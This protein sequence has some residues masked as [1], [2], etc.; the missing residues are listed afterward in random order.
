MWRWLV[1]VVVVGCSNS[2]TDGS[3]GPGPTASLEASTVAVLPPDPVVSITPLDDTHVAI[4]RGIVSGDAFCPDCVGLDPAQ[5]PLACTRTSI[6]LAILDTTTGTLG[7]EVPIQ[8]VFPKSFDHDV[9]ELQTVALGGNRVGLAWLDCD[10]S[11]CGA[12]AGKQSCSAR[13]S[14]IDLAAGTVGPI[15]TLYED[16]FGRLQLVASADH[17]LAVTGMSFGSYGAGVR[18][19]IFQHDGDP[20]FPWLALGGKD[21]LV[22][23]AAATA[24]GFAVVIEDR[25]P[26]DTPPAA[27]CP[28]SC[29][30]SG[31]I[32]IDPAGGGVYAYEL[33][34]TGI[35]RVD[36]VALGL[37]DDGHLAGGHY[38]DREVLALMRRGDDLVIAAGQAIDGAAELFVGRNDSWTTHQDFD[39]P[40]PLWI[41]VLGLGDTV[42]WIGS[43]PEPGAGSATIN[44]IVA[45]AADGTETDQRALTDPTDSYVFDAAPLVTPDGIE[46]TF[47]LRGVFDRSGA[48]LSWKWYEVV[49]VA[50]E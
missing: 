3:G 31:S 7:S 9:N 21:A 15:K 4:V 30:C 29:S 20:V 5:C 46:R 2:P 35:V 19:A 28:A 36:R 6:S 12:F 39:S 37:T 50:L 33:A 42:A 44:R 32:S 38:H 48:M 47:L 16:R 17:L 43:Q 14:V 11:R 1:V 23:A 26:S 49:E 45:G 13:Y 24:E 8:Q 18:A 10:N 40:I 27:P 34:A 22:P 41:G 25:R